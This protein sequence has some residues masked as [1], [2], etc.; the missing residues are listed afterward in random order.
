MHLLPS[1]FACCDVFVAL[2]GSP[3]KKPRRRRQGR[4]RWAGPKLL[5]APLV[6]IMGGAAPGQV[7]GEHCWWLLV[8]VDVDVGV[9]VGMGV[10]V[11]VA[12]QRCKKVCLFILFHKK[13]N[14]TIIY[15]NKMWYRRSLILLSSPVSNFC[16]VIWLVICHILLGCFHE[17][18]LWGESVGCVCLV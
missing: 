2:P 9:A 18:N 7:K 6:Q 4:G 5:L 11:G 8:D 15:M 1:S 12:C 13:R 17:F 3:L 10:A 16:V 14:D